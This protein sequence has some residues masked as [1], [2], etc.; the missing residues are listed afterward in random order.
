MC[1]ISICVI[2]KLHS[3]LSYHRFV[4]WR[5]S[6]VCF[7]QQKGVDSVVHSKMSNKSTYLTFIR[8][9]SQECLEIVWMVSGGGLIKV[10]KLGENLKVFGKVSGVKSVKV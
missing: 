3:N 2:L 4:G 10:T 5:R 8:G 1:I 6:W 9:V 7:S